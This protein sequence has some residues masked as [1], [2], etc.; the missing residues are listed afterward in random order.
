MLINLKYLQ[1]KYNLKL[2]TILHVGAHTCQ[3]YRI[4]DACGASNIFWVE[5]N[6]ELV[7]ENKLKL[8]ELQNTIIEAVVSE[9]D[10]E[11]VN[12]HIANNSQASSI[13]ELGSHKQLFPNIKYVESATKHTQKL[14][15][16]YSKYCNDMHIDLLNLD[17][18][19]A[20]L[21]A[22]K[23]FKKNL[24]RVS[25]IY[26]EINTDSVYKDCALAEHLDEFLSKFNFLRVETKMWKDH[27]WGDGFYIKNNK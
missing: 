20:E 19:G 8:N 5:G 27:P 12:F 2:D 4:Y 1:K 26:T 15:T 7:K 17:I 6:S 16:I 13:L 22:L 25:C 21:L 11:P 23:G 9:F 14:D 18:Q 24:H 10:D 3:E